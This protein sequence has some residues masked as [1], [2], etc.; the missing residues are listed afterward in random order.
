VIVHE[1]RIPELHFDESPGV[2]FV[3]KGSHGRSARPWSRSAGFLD[4]AFEAL[5]IVHVNLR[6]N[7]PIYYRKAS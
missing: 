5:N 1:T 6:G 3:S 7:Y 4:S 2:V